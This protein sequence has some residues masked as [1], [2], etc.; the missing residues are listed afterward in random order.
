[1][2]EIKRQLDRIERKLKDVESEA[3]DKGHTLIICALIIL[4]VRACT[5]I[6]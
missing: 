5:S 2:N 4:L 1:M 6:N 3:R